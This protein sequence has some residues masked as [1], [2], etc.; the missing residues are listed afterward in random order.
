MENSTSEINAKFE[1]LWAFRSCLG[2]KRILDYC[3]VPSEIVVQP[4]SSID[5]LNLGSDNRCVQSCILLRTEGCTRNYRKRRQKVDW[6]AYSEEVKK[7]SHVTAA[8]GLVHL[9]KQFADTASACGIKKVGGDAQIWNCPELR[10]LR[11]KRRQCVGAEE[12]SKITKL[13]WKVSRQQ[14]RKYRTKQIQSRLECF[15]ELQ[16]LEHIRVYPVKKHAIIKADDRKCA[17]SLENVYSTE[18]PFTYSTAC[19]VP[20]FTIG[21]LVHVAKNGKNV[22]ARIKLGLR[23]KCLFMLVLMFLEVFYF[24]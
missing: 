4:S 1:K 14:L 6:A 8:G 9:E 5:G 3:F 24:I 12:R 17:A 18:R 21:E 22:K 19:G 13:I 23:V 11:E 20:P 10:D 2:H 16:H 15:S 7:V